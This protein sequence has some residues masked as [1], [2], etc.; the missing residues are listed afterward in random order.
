MKRTIKTLVIEDS[1]NDLELILRSLE[2]DETEIKWRQILSAEEMMSALTDERWDLIIS[3]YHLPTFSAPAALAMLKEMGMDIPFITVSGCIGEDTAVAMMK[4]GAHDYV[5]KDRL[6]RLGP[7]VDRELREARVR[8]ERRRASEESRLNEE[9]LE[10]LYRLSQM[11]EADEME[12]MNYALEEGVR[13]TGSNTGYLYFTDRE[14][15]FGPFIFS[16]RF[17]NSCRERIATQVSKDKDCLWVEC[18][19]TGQPAIHNERDRSEMNMDCPEDHFHM[20]RHMGVPVFDGQSI[21]AVAGVGN[22]K[23]RYDETDVRQLSL[24]MNEMWKM[25]RRRQAEAERHALEAQLAQIQ[26]MNSIGRLAG[27]VAHDFNNLLTVILGN[28]ELMLYKIT[29]K[30]SYMYE[31]LNEIVK[32]GE[33]AKDLTRQL[34]AF[35]RK[36]RLEIKTVN[37]NEII[38]NFEKMLK[39]IIGEDIEIETS[40]DANLQ[41]I[42]ADTAKMEQIILNLAVNARDAMGR[43]G[44]IFIE[45]SNIT[46]DEEFAETH[47]GLKVGPSIVMTIRDTGCGMDSET[48]QHIFEPFFTTKTK[49]KGTGLGLSIVYG[50]VTQHGGH[51]HV[52]SE[53]GKG[54]TFKIYIPSITENWLN[55]EAPQYPA[56]ASE[57]LQASTADQNGSGIL[58]AISTGMEMSVK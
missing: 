31:L 14:G 11:T 49:E 15:S 21:V 41:S 29:D 17:S 13:L 51:I 26:K 38:S 46:I 18:F 22:K 27:G 25:I 47:P 23:D 50:I 52:E 8:R 2:S 12:V 45:T 42:N 48:L 56:N 30:N 1:D 44:K 33:K 34:L 5:M 58:K 3:D 35:G 40:L 32:A 20:S 53:P 16:D 28:S 43:G 54:T 6:V 24:F 4:S 55:G 10:S 7:V 57:G 9:R 19:N 37:L 39:R 36:Q